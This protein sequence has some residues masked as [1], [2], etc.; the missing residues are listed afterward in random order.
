VIK[1]K[2]KSSSGS[3]G[4]ATFIDKAGFGFPFTITRQASAAGIKKI[5]KGSSGG[6]EKANKEGIKKDS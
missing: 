2:A 1:R 3:G 4:R 6:I 5:N